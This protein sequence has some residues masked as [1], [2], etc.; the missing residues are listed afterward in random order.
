MKIY[1]AGSVRSGR[2]DAD[3]YFQ[4]IEHLK[5]YGEVLTEHLGSHGLT[6]LGETD[7]PDK[8]IH[9]RDI[10]WVIQADVVVAEVSTPSIGV[11]YEIGRAVEHKKKVLCLY[12]PQDGKRLS[13]MIAGSAGVTTC[14]YA[15]LEDAKKIMDDYFSTLHV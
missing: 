3:V 6:T 12:R 2:D 10:A 15:T 13:A 5:Q 8:H 7:A 9:D 14:E 4:I 1:F 11:G